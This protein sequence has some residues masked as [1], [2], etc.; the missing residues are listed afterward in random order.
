MTPKNPQAGPKGSA[1]SKP[2]PKAVVYTF[3]DG[4]KVSVPIAEV[5]R[6]VTNEAVRMAVSGSEYFSTLGEVRLREAGLSAIADVA[7]QKREARAKAKARAA[8]ASG[9]PRPS[10]RSPIRE[11][12]VAMMKLEKASGTA[13]K[14]LMQ[15]W[16]D[17]AIGDLVLTADGDKYSISDDLTGEQKTYTWGSLSKLFGT[18]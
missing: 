7:A 8:A 14:T 6:Q 11:R 18:A 15:R 3:S 10:N 16:A 4:S 2:V 17:E 1:A 5:N 9:A 13:F 12:I